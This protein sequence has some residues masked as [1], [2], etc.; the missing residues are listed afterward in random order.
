[1][2]LIAFSGGFRVGNDTIVDTC[3]ILGLY[4]ETPGLYY[5]MLVLCYVTLVDTR[6]SIAESE[7]SLGKQNEIPKESRIYDVFLLEIRIWIPESSAVQAECHK[8]SR[9]LPIG[10]P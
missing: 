5:V 7:G 6:E 3:V 9:I 4:Y 2:I 10:F 8:E 1:M